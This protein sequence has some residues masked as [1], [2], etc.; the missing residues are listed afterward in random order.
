M[1]PSANGLWFPQFEIGFGAARQ[2]MD[3]IIHNVKIMRK[4]LSSYPASVFTLAISD[5]KNF[6]NIFTSSEFIYLYVCV[7]FAENVLL[8][9]QI[10][11]LNGREAFHQ[12][13]I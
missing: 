6:C 4:R 9:E 8:I 11:L 13:I 12:C 3:P 5:A 7:P 1:V 10:F 2:I